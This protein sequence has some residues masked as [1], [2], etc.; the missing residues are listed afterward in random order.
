M[1]QQRAIIIGAGYGGMALANILGKAGYKVDVYEK[2]AIPGGRIAAIEQDGFT[3]DIGPSWYLMPEVFERYYELFD[4]SA[5]R[6]LDLVRF[7]PGYKVFFEGQDSVMIE[8]DIDK[9]KQ[10]FE[11]I[12]S[13]AG[14]RLEKYVGRSTKIYE[15]S[16]QY[17]LYNNYSR[18]RDVLSWLV[19]RHAPRMLTLVSR[20]LDH[21]VSKYF[22]DLRLKQLLEYHMVFLGSSP[23]QAPAIYSLMS[24][25]DFKSGVF[26]PKRGMMSLV[27]GIQALGQ[28]YDIT[29]HY[30]APVQQIIVQDGQAVGVKLQDGSVVH[31]DQVVSNADLHFTETQLLTP[32]SRAFQSHI[33]RSVNLVLARC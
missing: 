33:G 9:D 20:S 23:F 6:R 17:F 16:V 12:E 5:Q 4:A 3:F 18:V 21:Y 2:N 22:K 15:L 13:G 1:T 26:Y 11:Q 28:E 10:V 31:A 7:R 30:D 29:Y 8:G 19:I 24:H 25:L 14:A 32:A 27:D